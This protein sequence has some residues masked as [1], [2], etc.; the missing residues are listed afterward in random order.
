MLKKILFFI[1]IISVLQTQAQKKRKYSNEFLNLG[2]GAAGMGM[3]NSWVAG[4]EDLYG[5]YYNL[6]AGMAHI[7]MLFNWAICTASILQA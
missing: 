4:T 5:M 6:L 2:M 1:A 7:K 3:A